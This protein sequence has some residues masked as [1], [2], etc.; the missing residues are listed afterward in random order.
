[1]DIN[2]YKKYT[3]KHTHVLQNIKYTSVLT[4]S[5]CPL[6]EYNCI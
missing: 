1:M 2:M 3:H 5:I 6:V 4:C